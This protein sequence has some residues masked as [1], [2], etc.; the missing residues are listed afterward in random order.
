V[1][2][3]AADSR[4]DLFDFTCALIALRS[5]HP[6][7]RR[8]RFFSGELPGTGGTEV[9]DISWLTAAGTEMT[10]EDWR[11]GFAR[12]LA[13]LL[14]G[15]AITEPDS[16][17]ET[18]TDQSFLLLFNAGDEPVAF[19]LPDADATPGWEVVADTAEPAGDL[20]PAGTEPV[21]LTARTVAAR[22]VVILRR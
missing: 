20:P 17:G 8:R 4:G 9:R 2:W 21:L 15:D 1:D 12:S 5:E 18:I 7:F 11:S 10:V 6:V 3:E 22:S 19:T 14:N 16:R 13:V